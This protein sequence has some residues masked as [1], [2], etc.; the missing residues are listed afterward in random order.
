AALAACSGRQQTRRAAPEASSR[1]WSTSASSS[2]ASGRGG[3]HSAQQLRGGRR[4]GRQHQPAPKEAAARTPLGTTMSPCCCFAAEKLPTGAEISGSWRRTHTR[5]GVPQTAH[6]STVP[7]QQQQHRAAQDPPPAD[8][9]A[10]IRTRAASAGCEATCAA[11]SR[12][13]IRWCRCPQRGSPPESPGGGLSLA[14][15]AD[16]LAEVLRSENVGEVRVSAEVVHV[17]ALMSLRLSPVEAKEGRGT[18][19]AAIADRLNGTGA[20]G[21]NFVLEDGGGRC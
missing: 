18:R 4:R 2:L 5:A 6:Y 15:V 20:G 8:R 16:E 12:R 3:G 14:P 10:D 13:E 17:T 19:D 7:H 1:R 11:V 9:K 21:E